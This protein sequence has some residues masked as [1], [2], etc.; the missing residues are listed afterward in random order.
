MKKILLIITGISI[1]CSSCF[2]E[3]I[4]LDLNKSENQK[5]VVDAWITDLDE[6]QFVELS[7]TSNYIGDERGPAVENAEVTLTSAQEQVIL[8]HTEKGIYNLPTTWKAQVGETYTLE[9]LYDDESYIATSTLRPLPDVHN[10]RYESYEGDTTDLYD[11][12]FDFEDIPGEGDGYYAIDYKK[13]SDQRDIVGNGG[14][15]DDQYTD[16]IEYKD[17]TATVEDHVKGDTIILE[18]HSIGKKSTDY[19]NGV[20]AEIF[21]GFI[22]DPPPVN[23]KTNL[24]NGAVGF[25]IM[26]SAEKYQIIL[27]ENEVEEIN[28]Y[29]TIDTI[30]LDAGGYDLF[31]LSS[32]KGNQT[33]VLESGLGDDLSVWL[34]SGIAEEFVESSQVIIYNRAG[35]SPSEF[36]ED[37]PRNLN[38]LTNDLTKVISAVSQNEKVIL[39]GHSLG[40]AIIRNYAIQFPDKV[41]GLL[42]VDTSHEDLEDRDALQIMIDESVPQL[43]QA[44]QLATASEIAQLVDTYD[45]LIALPDLPD[46]PVHVLTS[47]ALEDE[48][49]MMEVEEVAL[50]FEAH[51]SLGTGVTNFTHI[52]TTNSGHHIHLDEPQ[53]VIT[54]LEQLIR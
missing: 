21:R 25:F 6:Q 4:E 15:I 14:W 47:M 17:I 29:I 9:I 38:E 35:Y 19:L 16:G 5:L 22:F 24:S 30:Q 27:G 10:I 36:S 26:A 41:E 20:V 44:G 28:E 46:L 12:Y 2:N 45:I 8:E 3:E 33:I 11:V 48:N 42:F 50:K 32:G 31:V 51:A 49:D 43:E 23:V 53:L 1:I 7:L 37:V 52:T 54:S 39:V 34:E 18:V 13:N 40:G